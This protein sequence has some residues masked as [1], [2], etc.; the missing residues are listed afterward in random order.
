ML[1][2]LL[3]QQANGELIHRDEI[4]KWIT[5]SAKENG[6]QLDAEQIDTLTIYAVKGLGRGFAKK[7]ESTKLTTKKVVESP[8]FKKVKSQETVVISSSPNPLPLQLEDLADDT[9]V[10]LVEQR[11]WIARY[12]TLRK[13]FAMQKSVWLILILWVFLNI[14]L[15]LIGFLCTRC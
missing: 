1:I 6:F 15:F 7:I 11:K 12:S 8:V 2:D 5:S 13:N 3:G 9:E 10:S 4:K 14:S